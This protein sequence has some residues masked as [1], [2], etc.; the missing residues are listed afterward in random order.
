MD[1]HE[2]IKIV[3]EKNG[4]ELLNSPSIINFLLDYQAFAEYPPAKLILRDIITAGYADKLLNLNFD[5]SDWILSYNKIK[6]QF[7]ESCGYKENLALY[8]FDSILYGLGIS[9]GT[10]QPE[11]SSTFDVESFFPS[12]EQS[13][14]NTN[15]NKGNTNNTSA[16]SYDLYLMA[17]SFFNEKKYLQAKSLIE[18]GIGFYLNP[19]VPSD[20]YKLYGDSLSKLNQYI[21]A[22]KAYSNF[23]NSK[24]KEMN[25]TIDELKQS[26]INHSV[27]GVENIVFNYNYCLFCLNNIDKQKWTN[28]VKSEARKGLLDAISY[29]AENSINP[30]DSHIDIYFNDINHLKNG[31]ILYSDGTFAH[32]E[33][34]SKKA[35]AYIYLVETSDF[36]KSQ[37]WTHGYI[38]PFEP[39]GKWGLVSY[40]SERIPWATESVD[41]PFPHSHFSLDDVRHFNE[42]EK[43]ESE[44]FI[45]IHDFDKYPAF[46][47][48]NDF[49]L[50]NPLNES[51]QWFLPSVH[52]VERIQN[53]TKKSIKFIVGFST[54]KIWT[55]SQGDKYHAIGYYSLEGF[56]FNLKSEGRVVLPIAAF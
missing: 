39:I 26:L 40:E 23:F 18:K 52:H 31:D 37:G 27:K 21:D 53:L 17:L 29:C 42:I 36:E 30:I 25:V 20:Y 24:A 9:Y 35:I 33:S 15:H 50:R 55:S 19:D 56:S 46:K 11:V 12:D 49:K 28:F 6:Y 34:K 7:I 13:T 54:Y 32:E 41:C 44:Q 8:V 47:A 16:N 10:T 45:K 2:A 51:S 22:I 43:I 4:K 5:N 1:L 14:P 48:V 3:V 38:V